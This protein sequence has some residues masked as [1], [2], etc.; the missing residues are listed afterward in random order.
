MSISPQSL[1][2]FH[3]HV[4]LPSHSPST[5]SVSL[6]RTLLAP[7]CS[8]LPHYVL[9]T[10]SYTVSMLSY[11][12]RCCLFTASRAACVTSIS[13]PCFVLLFSSRSTFFF[14][15]RAF[16]LFLFLLSL[17][18]FV[19]PLYGPLV[20]FP[21]TTASSSLSLCLLSSSISLRCPSL[22]L[23]SPCLSAVLSFRYEIDRHVQLCVYEQH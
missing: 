22:L 9:R 13:S 7:H 11:I 12:S 20:F 5:S 4:H 8:R 1:T 19:S 16:Y 15:N 2:H 23:R 3:L 18:L 14:S 6:H 10:L 21:T 17:F